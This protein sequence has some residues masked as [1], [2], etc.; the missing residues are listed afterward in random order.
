MEFGEFRK[1]ENKDRKFGSATHY[2]HIRMDVEGEERPTC[3]DLLF[4]EQEL[5]EAAKRAADNPEDYMDLDPSKGEI[6]N[7][8]AALLGL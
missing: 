1:V 2:W 4:T 8:F 5:E 7:F 3:V 6:S